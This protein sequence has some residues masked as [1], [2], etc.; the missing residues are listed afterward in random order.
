MGKFHIFYIFLFKK[1]EKP[2]FLNYVKYHG[3][4]KSEYSRIRK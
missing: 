1:L 3:H 2:Y 4:V